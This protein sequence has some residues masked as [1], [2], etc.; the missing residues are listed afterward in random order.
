MF[1]PIE[2]LKTPVLFLIYKRLETTKRVF[3]II[4]KVRPPKLY[5][6]GDG[7]KDWVKGEPEKVR[8]VREFVSNNI[9]WDCAVKTLFRDKNLGCGIAVS[10]ALS[11]FFQNEEQ[12][13][14]LEDDTLPSISFFWF[15]EKLLEIYK[16][17][18]RIGMISGNN[19]QDG[20]KRGDGD[21]Y[22]SSFAHIWGWASWRD[23]WEGYDFKLDSFS[24]DK[25]IE[26]IWDDKKMIK[27]WK[28]V[29]WITKR[30]KINNWDAQWCFHLWKRKMLTILPNVN[31]VTNI[32]AG[33]DATFDK[34]KQKGVSEIPNYE[35]DIYDLKHPSMI[36]RDT[37]ADQYTFEKYIY[38]PIWIK[39]VNRLKIYFSEGLSKLK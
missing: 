3:E 36:I 22:F 28:R 26:E 7:P 23:R 31:L 11:W 8:A 5:I 38:K 15:C 19:F 4:R 10:E 27:F 25:F 18:K 29:F 33:L 32:G 30:G 39:I 13:I 24:D 16:D 20:I 12:G 34:V 35:I 17:D 14:I 9:D 6:A 1:K 37:Q 21:Y 2:P